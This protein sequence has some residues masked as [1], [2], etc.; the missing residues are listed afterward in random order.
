M[1]IGDGAESWVR[2]GRI[3]LH[4]AHDGARTSLARNFASYPFHVTRPFYF[5]AAW[6]D[7]PTVVLQSASGGL[8]QGDR[9]SIEISVGE[10]ASVQVTSQSAM[11]IHSMERDHAVQEAHLKIERNGYLEVI[12]DPAILFPDS[13]VETMTMI[14]LDQGASAILAESF[15]WHDPKGGVAPNFSLASTAIE[16]RDSA[17]RLLMKDRYRVTRPDPD[18]ATTADWQAMKGQGTVYVLCQTHS[19]AALVEGLRSALGGS[20]H[21]YVGVSVLPNEAG[22]FVRVLA[23]DVNVIHKVLARAC[24]AARRL[25]VGRDTRLTWRK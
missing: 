24:R 18:P 12:A 22:A 23:S 11:K 7:L 10:G 8:F 17:G 4:F 19:G 20:G 25:V 6:P 13:T 1:N 15:F 2:R 5:D 14:E 3:K 16:V 9:L 21:G